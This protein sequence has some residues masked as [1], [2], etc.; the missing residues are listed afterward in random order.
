MGFYSDPEF[1]ALGGQP[2]SYKIGWIQSS[3]M[4]AYTG[5]VPGDYP[6]NGFSLIMEDTRRGDTGLPNEFSDIAHTGTV[7]QVGFQMNWD[8]TN[9]APQSKTALG[10]YRTTTWDPSVTPSAPIQTDFPATPI[11]VGIRHSKYPET[12]PRYF[13]DYTDTVMSISIVN[14][15]PGM[16]VSR[17]ATS[18]WMWSASCRATR[19]WTAWSTTRTPRSS[20]PTG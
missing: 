20:G 11:A 1:V 19:T 9:Y 4:V 7:S 16:G 14:D 17:I 3:N 6:T 18:R 10:E 2:W 13:D 5:A 12:N 15:N 8:M